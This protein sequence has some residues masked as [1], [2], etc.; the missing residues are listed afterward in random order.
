MRILAVD[1]GTSSVKA[2]VASRAADGGW[3]MHACSAISLEPPPD[4]GAAGETE[5]HPHKWWRALVRAVRALSEDT[6]LNAVE[7]FGLS[8][9]MQSV[10]LV[11]SAGGALRPALLY[12]DTR[13]TAEAAELEA[14]LGLDRLQAA[15]F[16]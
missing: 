10:I 9:Q 11:D 13:S 16:A 2:V 14:K 15:N 12:S 5:Q 4:T 6:D 3:V 1:A 8:G 7:A